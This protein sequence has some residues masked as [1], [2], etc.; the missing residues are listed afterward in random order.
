MDSPYGR[1][2][3]YFR[4]GLQEYLK[5]IHA[6]LGGCPAVLLPHQRDFR[7][8]PHIW[9]CLQHVV[10]HVDLP[11]WLPGECSGSSHILMKHRSKAGPMAGP[12]ELLWGSEYGPIRAV[13]VPFNVS[14]MAVGMACITWQT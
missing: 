3:L 10:T 11:M 9:A 1:C 7:V 8:G 6:Y 5:E 14:N 2:K 4:E 13:L 12:E